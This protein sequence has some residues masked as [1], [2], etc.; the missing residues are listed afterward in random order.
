MIIS[1]YILSVL[2]LVIGAAHFMRSGNYGIMIFLL[3][4]PFLFFIR[5]RFSLHILA[6]VLFLLA[7]EWVITAVNLYQL[8]IM[9]NMPATR[10]LFI[11]SSVAL[12]T[13]F[14]GFLLYNS[15]MLR[16]YPRQRADIAVTAAFFLTF[17]LIGFP[18][19]KVDFPVI[20]LERFL[21]GFGW[22]QVGIMSLY[23]SLV[24]FKLSD[25]S[26]MKKWRR[27]I[28]TTFSVVFFT[29]LLFGLL[30]IDKML[31]T[32]EL[33]IP[34]PAV[35]LAG[36]LYRMESS[37]MIF[38]FLGSMLLLG[39]GWCSYLCYF[40]AW[41]NKAA[42]AKKYPGKMPKNSQII[43]GVILIIVILAA[44][45]M[46]VGGVPGI[47]AA[48]AGIFFGLAGV[49]VMLFW[50]RKKGVMTHCTTYCPIGLLAII[51]GKISPFRMKI[52]DTSCTDCMR[53]T[54][55]CRYNALSRED[56]KNRKP[57]I[58]CTLCGDCVNEC[59]VKE[60]S[61]NFRF[62]KMKPETARKFYIT[63]AASLHTVFMA[64]GRV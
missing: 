47:Y 12:F 60:S 30:G 21:P 62:L 33:H 1:T 51:F 7:V 49:G 13:V 35:I 32:G 17:A 56:V 28:W 9:M 39:P 11:M 36:P 48:G 42:D 55:V 24:A 16:R 43:R 58:N 8:R 50:S 44:I 20:L 18:F 31:M 57:N 63:M 59:E 29:Q 14:S 64:I 10:M 46:N 22:L 61:I 25:R 34:V 15:K 41:D 54:A 40:G 37:I 27:I 4:L 53:C 52:D 2:S 38:L 5:K 6:G 23:A 19:I 3:L 26:K 45:L